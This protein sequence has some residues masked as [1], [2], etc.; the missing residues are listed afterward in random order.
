MTEDGGVGMG[1]LQTLQ[2]AAQCALLCRGARVLGVAVRV[3]TA[4]VAYSQR[5]LVIAS[6]M[7]SGQLFVACLGDGAVAFHVV[8]VAGE[9]EA[10]L[11]AAYQ[12][13]QREAPVLASS[14]AVDDDE[15]DGSHRLR[16]EG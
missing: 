10:V 3:Q 9:A 8:V 5:M 12:V 13:H 11:V 14:R 7:C 1:F 15:F 16:V 2:Q 4:F 6:G